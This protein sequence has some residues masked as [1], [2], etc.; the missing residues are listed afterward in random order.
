LHDFAFLLFHALYPAPLIKIEH[1]FFLSPAQLSELSTASYFCC[2]HDYQSRAQLPIL[3]ASTTIRIERSIFI[4]AELFLLLKWG[5][6]LLELARSFS[7][8]RHAFF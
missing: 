5:E 7:F 1:V 3:V 6:N 2:L 4:F 8:Y